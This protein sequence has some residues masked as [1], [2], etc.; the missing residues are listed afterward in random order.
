MMFK[1]IYNKHLASKQLRKQIWGAILEQWWI[2]ALIIAPFVLALRPLI[3]LVGRLFAPIVQPLADWVELHF[4]PYSE[5]FLT[6]TANKVVDFHIP[7]D[8]SD[9]RWY[10]LAFLTLLILLVILVCRRLTEIFSLRKKEGGITWCQISILIAIGVW[11]V[12]FLIIFDT[13]NN[14]RLAAAIGVAGSLTAW[15][16]QDTIKGVVAFIHLRL[17][18]LLQIDDWIKVPKYNVDG[19]VKRVTL[20]T[21]TIYNWDTTT[22]SIPTSVLHSDHFINLKKMMD[23]KTYGRRMY[24]TFILDTGWFHIVTE[25]EA[26]VLRQNEEIL[27]HIPGNEIKCGMSNAHLFRIYLFHYLM[28]H[29]HISQQP[30]LIVR[31][32]DQTECGMPLQVYAF[33]T[34]SRLPA[35]EKQQSQ[36][37]EHIIESLEWFGLRLYQSPSSYDVSN[38]NIY[39]T[40]KPATYRKETVE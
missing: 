24:K 11:I 31:W 16:F 1:K 14:S 35:F 28:N 13:K 40:Q 33:I 34:D 39:L 3:T 18:H 27:R 6:G 25:E 32:M 2:L 29:S 4:L 9:N 8:I 30:R 22:S 26:N 36:I 17:N 12:G 19:E 5:R 7:Y 15:I 21:V 10:Q 20:T 23:G 37:I 38:S